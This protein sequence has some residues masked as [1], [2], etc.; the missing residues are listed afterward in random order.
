MSNINC[1]ICGNQKN[2]KSFL[3]SE[4][5]FGLGEKFE[6]FECE[7][8]GCLQIKEPLS[9]LTKYYPINY[10]SFHNIISKYDFFISFL[11]RQMANYYIFKKNNI[12]GMFLVYFFSLPDFFHWLK[13]INL[14][15][16]AKIL[17]VGCGQGH[18]L[19][20][21]R[22]AGYQN[23]IG[24]DAYL[25]HDLFYK[26]N[27]KIY[28]KELSQI[29]EK[30]DFIIL[31]H[32]FE[33]MLNP[34]AVIKK[35]YSLL[36][37][38]GHLLIRVPVASSYAWQHYGV[39]WVQLDAPRHIFIPSVKS[40]EILSKTAGFNR[41]EVEFDSNDFQFWGSEQYQKSIPLRSPLSYAENPK[42]SIFT[43]KQ[44]QDFKN[45]AQKLNKNKK[46]D[47]AS[48]YFFKK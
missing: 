25:D 38:G 35:T 16:K 26:N 32:S 22:R 5:M 31:N 12:F 44:I 45:Q 19:I 9:D 6:Y 20:G 2:N 4:M 17:D 37:N 23:L 33:H 40:M 24:I 36:N 15:S 18:L 48:F 43:K 7:K 8:C 41:V 13:K 11:R 14:N 21:L 3:V 47:T 28:K 10:Y 39:S 27:V 1:L 30:F 34:Q 29:S 46:G 42:K